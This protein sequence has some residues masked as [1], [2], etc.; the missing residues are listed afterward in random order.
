MRDFYGQGLV[1][2]LEQMIES[3]RRH[4]SQTTTEVDPDTGEEIEV[5][6]GL[7]LP[8]KVVTEDVLDDDGNPTGEKSIRFIEHSPGEGGRLSLVWG[9]PFPSTPQ[10]KQQKVTTLQSAAGGK[11][12]LSHETTVRLAAKE[13]GL[14]ADAEWARIQE[15]QKQA[16]EQEAGMFLGTGGQVE[17]L[18]ELPDG[19]SAL[20]ETSTDRSDTEGVALDETGATE[21]VTGKPIEIT[22]A[23]VL[24]GA[25]I[26]AAVAIVKSV[27]AEEIPRDAGLGQLRILFNL[28]DE[29]ALA[30]MGSA[31][32]TP[33]LPN[34]SE[35]PTT[36]QPQL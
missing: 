23:Q 5:S 14:D 35:Q 9:D 22:S 27:V 8:Q 26:Q 11:P 33:A 21:T 20:P 2:L 25:Q 18:D 28:T 6:Y 17:S 31:G 15:E 1:R 29:Q 12:V 24:N 30:L 34:L 16:R 3:A 7:D 19:A 36:E 4:T 32:L 13:F 10:E